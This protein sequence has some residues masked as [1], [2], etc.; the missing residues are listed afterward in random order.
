MW[1]FNLMMSY[2]IISITVVIFLWYFKYTS[3]IILMWFYVH[4]FERRT[5]SLV[6]VH[7]SFINISTIWH[8]EKLHHWI[9]CSMSYWTLSLQLCAP[10]WLK[11]SRRARWPD[12][13]PDPQASAAALML[14]LCYHDCYSSFAA[15]EPSRERRTPWFVSMTI[16][17]SIF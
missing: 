17:A 14:L 7:C 3:Q 12:H 15:A 4:T 6:V 13:H 1:W 16:E 9:S 8:E 5:F 10:V 2:L 11:C